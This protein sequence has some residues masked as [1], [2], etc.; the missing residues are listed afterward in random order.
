MSRQ[1]LHEVRSAAAASAL[2]RDMARDMRLAS[3][4]AWASKKYG[5]TP[6][7]ASRM[8]VRWWQELELTME[9]VASFKL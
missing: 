5:L 3:L 8:V 2:T 1:H 9:E 6:A 7:E 4:A